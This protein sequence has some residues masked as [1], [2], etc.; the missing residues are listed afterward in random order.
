MSGRANLH[1]AADHRATGPIGLLSCWV[2]VSWATVP[3]TNVRSGWCP[4]G[5]CLSVMSPRGSVRQ[6]S[7]RSGY[8]SGI[9]FQVTV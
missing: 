4:S 1:W 7:V 8:C 5:Y 2:T 9:V 3:R 6:A